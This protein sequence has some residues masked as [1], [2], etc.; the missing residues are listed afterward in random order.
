[1]DENQNQPPLDSL[2][3]NS[4]GLD[5]L[6]RELK[7]LGE[8][9]F[10]KRYPCAFL[11]LQQGPTQDDD[12]MDLNTSESS[13]PRPN[14]IASAL[15]TIRAIPL[16]KSNRNAFGSKITVGRARNND[17]IVRA[18]KISKLHAAFYSGAHGANYKLQDMGSLNGTVVNGRRL[19]SKERSALNP[20]DVIT[21]WRYVFEFVSLDKMLER[22]KLC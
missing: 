4:L 21:F 3:L 22:I 16:F 17:V 12:W 19:H 13:L 11:I 9:A 20:G 10:R 15:S 1:V 14:E 5:S 18:P 6:A 7:E 2:G 8:E